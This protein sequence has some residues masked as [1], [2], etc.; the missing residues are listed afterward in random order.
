MGEAPPLVGQR[1]SPRGASPPGPRGDARAF[2][3][4]GQRVP[5]LAAPCY[6]GVIPPLGI[7]T[8]GAAMRK[9]MLCELLWRGSAPG[10]RQPWARS[11]CRVACLAR[12]RECVPARRGPRRC[13]AAL[14]PKI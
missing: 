11:D 9:V 1:R 13:V 7:R 12:A 4:Q 14:A 3:L 10:R 5:L 2:A 8:V 6:T